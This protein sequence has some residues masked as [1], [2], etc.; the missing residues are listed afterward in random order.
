MKTTIYFYPCSTQQILIREVCMSVSVDTAKY[1]QFYTLQRLCT[2]TKGL[3]HPQTIL[4]LPK[5]TRKRKKVKTRS[6]R[7]I[8]PP[9]A[10]LT[11]SQQLTTTTTCQAGASSYNLVD[12]DRAHMTLGCMNSIFTWRNFGP[13]LPGW[14]STSVIPRM[15][16]GNHST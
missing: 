12:Q 1:T 3:N 8:F 7:S 15:T 16:P 2:F 14:L 4:T 6:F 9:A 5:V 10:D 13:F 11:R